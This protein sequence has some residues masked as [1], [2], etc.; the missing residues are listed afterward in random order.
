MTPVHMLLLSFAGCVFTL[1]MGS[2]LGYHIYLVLCVLSPLSPLIHVTQVTTPTLVL[3]MA[4]RIKR[5]SRT[6]RPSTSYDTSPRCPPAASQ[7][8]PKSTNSR[9][10]SAAPYTRPT[11][12]YASTTSAG[13]A[14]RRRCLGPW[15]RTAAGA[16]GPL[17]CYGAVV[18]TSTILPQALANV[19]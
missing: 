7:V 8:R 9:P 15:G 5:R 4:V 19:R 10:H 2:F 16:L 13:G 1:V 6:S 3:G 11:R 12:A 17:G 14:T 18:G